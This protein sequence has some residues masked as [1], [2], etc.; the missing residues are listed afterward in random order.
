[1]PHRFTQAVEN[2]ASLRHEDIDEP[3]QYLDAVKVLAEELSFH[4]TRLGINC[5]AVYDKATQIPDLPPNFEEGL[6]ACIGELEHDPAFQK[7]ESEAP[8][9]R[10]TR[11]LARDLA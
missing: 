4:I 11:W 7:A 10:S 3:Q 9:G 2:L 5:E 1:M 6:L 8:G